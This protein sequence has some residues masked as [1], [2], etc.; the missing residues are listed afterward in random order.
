MFDLPLFVDNGETAIV[1]SKEEKE[2][3]QLLNVALNPTNQ[4]TPLDQVFQR[5]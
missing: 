1:L 4:H 3:L 5:R 2:T